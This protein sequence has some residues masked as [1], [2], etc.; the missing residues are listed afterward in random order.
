MVSH[1]LMLRI[2]SI[3]YID[4]IFLEIITWYS[5]AGH[6]RPEVEP[7]LR[8]RRRTIIWTLKHAIVTLPTINNLHC[9]INTVGSQF[10]SPG[11]SEVTQTRINHH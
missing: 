1:S 3:M 10:P 5:F 6:L 2:V 9:L 7:I 11:N 8:G 4:T